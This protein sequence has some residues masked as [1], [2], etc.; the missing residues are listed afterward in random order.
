MKIFTAV[1]LFINSLL[2][3]REN[4]RNEK[5]V[6]YILHPFPGT[7]FELSLSR[8][9]WSTGNYDEDLILRHNYQTSYEGWSIA[10][11]GKA[12]LKTIWKYC[13]EFVYSL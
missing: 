8:T 5:N 11:N 3:V 9:T 1:V 6:V 7:T 12:N 10:E 13:R 4:K 2:L